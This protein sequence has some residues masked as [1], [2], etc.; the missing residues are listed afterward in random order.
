MGSC[1][2][3]TSSP[4]CSAKPERK[5]TGFDRS[6]LI[7]ANCLLVA[8]FRVNARDAIASAQV[9]PRLPATVFRAFEGEGAKEVTRKQIEGA[10][11]LHRGE[12][13]MEEVQLQIE[14]NWAGALRRAV[15][16]RHVENGSLVAG[17]SVGML[18]EEE[19]VVELIANL[20]P[21][22]EDALARR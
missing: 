10:S 16:D 5:E 4:Q 20:M 6:A 2:D 1:P 13:A 17:Q 15:I 3:L 18:K 21:R 8:F 19:P 22:S 12:I 9:D 11:V 14:Y 7:A